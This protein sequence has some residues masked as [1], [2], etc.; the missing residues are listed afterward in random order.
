MLTFIMRL[1]LLILALAAPCELQYTTGGS[2]WE[3]KGHEMRN[4]AGNG[5]LSSNRASAVRAAPE[6]L[7]S[8]DVA[9]TQLRDTEVALPQLGPAGRTVHWVIR[10]TDLLSTLLFSASVLGQRVLRHEENEAACPVT[11]NGHQH[12]LQGIQAGPWS[13][14][15]VG[16]RTEDEGYALEITHTYGVGMYP[17]GQQPSLI[18]LAV[19][20]PDPETSSI[21]AAELGWA[22]IPLPVGDAILVHGPDMYRYV[23]LPQRRAQGPTPRVHHVALRVSDLRAAVR[24][25]TGLLRMTELPEYSVSAARAIAVVA[26]GAAFGK[27]TSYADVVMSSV[28]GYPSSQPTLLSDHQV[29]LVLL[30]D[31]APVKR[32]DWSGRHAVALPDAAIRAIATQLESGS[33]FGGRIVHPLQE[34]QEK[35]GVL[36]LL[37]VADPDGNELCLVSR[38]TFEVEARAATNFEAPDWKMRKLIEAQISTNLESGA[39]V[40]NT[41]AADSDN[42]LTTVA[43]E[44]A[45]EEL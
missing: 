17:P 34:L 4:S 16:A 10:S 37:I 13:K 40:L 44:L 21:A 36:L 30:D 15:M 39:S 29:P 18:E 22:S 31:G 42:F 25:Y 20:V 43:S 14:T 38:S 24:F 33:S 19:V 41:T 28:V 5:E 9:A 27:P 2:T 3:H 32:T 35:L 11:C 6:I 1:L 8:E 12:L 7:R 23:L 45:R 26:A